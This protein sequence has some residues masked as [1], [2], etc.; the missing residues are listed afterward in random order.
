MNW[1]PSRL[2]T[3]PARHRGRQAEPQ[4][5]QGRFGDDDAADRD[6][7][8]DDHR[9]GDVRPHVAPQDVPGS[10]ADGARG[11]EVVADQREAQLWREYVDRYHYLGYT[12]LPGAQMRYLVLPLPHN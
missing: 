12:P 7:E 9:R 4:E 3:A 1:R 2:S 5:A 10:A 8:H 11:L 6:R